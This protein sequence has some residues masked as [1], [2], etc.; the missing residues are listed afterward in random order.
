MLLTTRLPDHRLRHF[1]S[2]GTRQEYFWQLGIVDAILPVLRLET[3]RHLQLLL[4]CGI[5]P[6]KH[7]PR[8]LHWWSRSRW[9]MS[10]GLG[11]IP[12]P[13]SGAY[14]QRTG[15]VAWQKAEPEGLLTRSL[16]PTSCLLQSAAG[17]E[18]RA[19]YKEALMPNLCMC[20]CVRLSS[21]LHAIWG[22][23]LRT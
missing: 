19:F 14:C 15:Q 4:F 2:Y 10:F 8:D 9:V 21:R 18:K 22:T 23:G 7:L 11:A 12:A 20:C 6:I 1:A 13:K 5:K 3:V 16:H 17:D